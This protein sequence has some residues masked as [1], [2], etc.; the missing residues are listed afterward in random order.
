M[1]S[2]TLKSGAVF[3][4]LSFFAL[5]FNSWASEEYTFPVSFE[6]LVTTFSVNSDGSF[7]EVQEIS[8]RIENEEGVSRYGEKKISY[9]PKLES[10]KILEAYTILPNGTRVKVM[11][12]SIRAAKGDMDS[13]SA[14]YSDTQ[15]KVIIFPNVVMGS[16][17]YYKYLRTRHV[18]LFPGQFS[19]RRTLSPFIKSAYVEININFDPRLGLKVD[20]NGFE[21]GR[22]ADKEGRHRYHFTQ[23]QDNVIP[24]EAGQAPS[25][26][27]APY[28]QAS[29]Y[30]NYEALGHAYQ[31][32][33]G[34]MTN[35]T[36]AIQKLADELTMGVA[37]KRQQT[38]LLYN[39]V[40]KNIRYVGS[41]IGNGGYVPHASQSILDNRWGDC[42]DHVV[43]L[44]ALLAAKGIESSPALIGTSDTYVLPKL[45]VLSAF[46]HVIT[47]VPSLDLY[48]DSTAQFTPMGTL[49]RE[50]LDKPVVLTALNRM[51]KTP[52]ML[53][54]ENMLTT[55]IVLKIHADGTTE[56]SSHATGTGIFD[57]YLRG[58][59]VAEKSS[60]EKEVVKGMLQNFNL[61]GS[62]K[63][64]SS[65]PTDLDKLLEV[66]STFVF[67]AVSNFPGPAS[68]PIKPG[69]VYGVIEGKTIS[70]P[71]DKLYLPEACPS[72]A[73]KDHYKIEFPATTKI[74][75]LP[76][77]VNY[78]DALVQYTA[79]YELKENKLEIKRE[80]INQN[81]GML[82][83]EAENELAK[84]F[85]PVFL[86][87]MRAQ[88]M[89]E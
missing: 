62:G 55:S 26:A 32:K 29:T 14:S 74:T 85:F 22:I 50:D 6:K 34:P 43:I 75:H 11:P 35:V 27:Y 3:I 15:Y 78:A 57:I 52:P 79:T 58:T 60:S 44:E 28:V 39:W 48:L 89:Y 33:A 81:P 13:R 1:R 63:I 72:V 67:D 38:R 30:A 88:V 31:G 66:E 9:V 19:V 24:M 10:V 68:M 61:S 86:R 87:D 5:S 8:T 73:L 40:S 82:C 2:R 56:G 64:K 18:P 51:G 37:D 59:K 80:L 36:P 12:N 41:Y 70:K 25:D 54:R 84:K 47:Y 76:E 17:L 45:A 83:G 69:I 46:N 20:S 49:P 23:K 7:Q 16:Q 71:K 4:A 42:K 65:D 77:N 21:G 53:A